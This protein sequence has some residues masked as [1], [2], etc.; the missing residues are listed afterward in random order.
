MDIEVKLSHSHVSLLVHL[1]VFSSLHFLL[2]TVDV[3][4]FLILLSLQP[5]QSNRVSDSFP[6]I[7]DR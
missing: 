7:D 4:G 2:S 1:L 5:T 6:H 3:A